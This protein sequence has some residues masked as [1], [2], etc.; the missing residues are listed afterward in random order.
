MVNVKDNQ[1]FTMF[2]ILF[3]FALMV[4]LGVLVARILE[5]VYLVA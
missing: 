5:H 4:I 3:D 1:S 2:F